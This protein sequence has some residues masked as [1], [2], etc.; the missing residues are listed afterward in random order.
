MRI[1][2]MAFVLMTLFCS[3]AC[4]VY[5]QENAFDGVRIDFAKKTLNSKGIPEGW[6][7]KG[8]PGVNDPKYEIVKDENGVD[9]L[10]VSCDKASGAILFDLKGVDL[11]KYPVMRWKWKNEKLPAGADG[12]VSAK[13]DQGIAIYLG[14]GGLF[15][16]T[17]VAY[18]WETETEKGKTG[19]AKYGAGLVSVAWTATRNKSDALNSWFV[20]Q[21]NAVAALKKEL[22]VKKLPSKG[23]A[24]S[25]SSNSQYTGTDSIAYLEYIEFVPANAVTPG[26]K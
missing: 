13:D 22:D 26:K 12:T 18:R 2:A 8:K 19:K 7:Y 20:D 6:T 25:V 23:I 11:E 21:V 15:G 17:S 4:F 9:V 16:Q 24:V 5:G 14:S 3:A 1:T 10:K